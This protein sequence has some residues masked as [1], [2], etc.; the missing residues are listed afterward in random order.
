MRFALSTPMPGNNYA[1][2]TPEQVDQ[3]TAD[4]VRKELMK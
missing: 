3:M 1:R 4:E 2:Y